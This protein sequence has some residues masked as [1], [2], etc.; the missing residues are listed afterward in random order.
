MIESVRNALASE[1]IPFP[2]KKSGNTVNNQT[3][4]YFV[5]SKACKTDSIE[6]FALPKREL[7]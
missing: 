7:I 3:N 6:R 5:Q 4:G 2:K 1:G